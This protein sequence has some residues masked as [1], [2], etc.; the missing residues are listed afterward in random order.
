M[1]GSSTS[2]D[3]PTRNFSINPRA[4]N[5]QPHELTKSAQK[6]KPL[7]LRNV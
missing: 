6:Y 4:C 1:N 3:V 5:V 2:H 7:R